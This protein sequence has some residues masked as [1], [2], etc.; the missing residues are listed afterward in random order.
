MFNKKGLIE[1]SDS[2]SILHEEIPDGKKKYTSDDNEEQEEPLEEET[3]I[4]DPIYKSY[5][6]FFE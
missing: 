5:D 6:T 4:N 2:L 1:L 3:L